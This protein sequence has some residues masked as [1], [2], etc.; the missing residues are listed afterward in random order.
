MVALQE[1]QNQQQQLDMQ[2]GMGNQYGPQMQVGLSGS[3]AGYTCKGR[4][5]IKNVFAFFW[6]RGLTLTGK[7]LLLR[8]Q[9]FP[10]KENLIF[11]R[12][13]MCRKPNWKTPELSPFKKKKMTKTVSSVSIP[14]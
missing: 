7:D 10:L 9:I 11:L 3:K 2:M 5:S 4:K 8:E 1:Q 6:H 13:L 14:L 12:G